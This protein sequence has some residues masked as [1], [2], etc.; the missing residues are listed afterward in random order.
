MT[1][2]EKVKTVR[3]KL[4]LTQKQLA[5][6]IGVQFY[7]VK[8]RWENEHTEPTFLV[9]CRF[10]EFCKEHGFEFEE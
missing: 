3:G 10:D 5:E 9:R 1:F 7:T 8:N 6:K 2:A 4:Q